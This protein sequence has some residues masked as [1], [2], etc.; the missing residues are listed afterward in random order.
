MLILLED[1]S[2]ILDLTAFNYNCVL[3][4]IRIMYV[5]DWVQQIIVESVVGIGNFKNEQIEPQTHLRYFF[6]SLD[7]FV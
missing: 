5:H 7:V 1:N 3:F 2:Y 6:L 4:W